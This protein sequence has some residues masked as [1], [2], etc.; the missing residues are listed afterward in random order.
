MSADRIV[1]VPPE[2]MAMGRG[3]SRCFAVSSNN[4]PVAPTI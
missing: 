1:I 3:F 4:C 2:G